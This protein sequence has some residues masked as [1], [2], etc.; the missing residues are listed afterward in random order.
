VKIGDIFV[1]NLKIYKP[2]IVLH[3]T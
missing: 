3:C 2:I 1:L